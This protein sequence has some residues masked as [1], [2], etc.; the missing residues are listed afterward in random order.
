MK[1]RG[2][3]WTLNELSLTLDM[4]VQTLYAWLRKGE[5]KARKVNTATRALWLVRA[6]K[7]ELAR[8]RKLRTKTRIWS[9]TQSERNQDRKNN[10]KEA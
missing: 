5:L 2:Q 8:L 1:K 7:A 6:N 10:L 4:P 9:K 3:E